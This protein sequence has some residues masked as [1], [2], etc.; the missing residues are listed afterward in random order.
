MTERRRQRKLTFFKNQI[1][2][3]SRPQYLSECNLRNNKNC[4]LHRC[5]PR[6]SE[7]SFIPSTGRI[8]NILSPTVRNL[9]TTSQFKLKIKGESVRPTIIMAGGP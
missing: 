3:K 1:Y 6:I 4:V 5:R 2:N 8:W 9:R 7:K